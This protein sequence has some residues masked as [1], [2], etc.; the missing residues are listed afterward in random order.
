[1]PV[2]PNIG[3]AVKAIVTAKLPQ[4]SFKNLEQASL[5]DW[6]YFTSASFRSPIWN[7]AAGKQDRRIV[8]IYTG[9]KLNK[10]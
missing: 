8:W 3:I 4:R 6:T 1:M 2:S 5:A 9:M 7:P 10:R